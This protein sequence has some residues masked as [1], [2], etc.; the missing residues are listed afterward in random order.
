[1]ICITSS[2][3]FPDDERIY[4][5]QIKS[6]VKNKKK[7]LYITRSQKNID[8]SNDL[9]NHINL[10]ITLSSFLESALSIII[11][12]NISHL[13]VH[14]TNLLPLIKSIKRL[15]PSVV[16]I[17]DV[18]EDM[19]S[20]YRTFTTRNIFISEVAIYF[21]NKKEEYY[22]KYVDKIILANS[23]IKKSSYK[24]FKKELYFLENFPQKKYIR[25]SIKNKVRGPLIVYHGHLAP[26]RG[27]SDLVEAMVEVLKAEPL[28]TLTLLGTFRIESFKK[29]VTALIKK[30]KLEDCISVRAQIPYE[31]VWGVLRKH[32]IGVIPFRSNPLTENNT[33]TK[34]FEMMASGLEIVATDLHPIRYFL[35]KTIFWATPNQSSS[36]AESLIQAIKNLEDDSNLNENLE[37]VNQRY[38]WEKIELKYLSTFQQ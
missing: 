24:N 25:S 5:R 36:L 27:I 19:K 3:H 26:E 34:L 31:E 11:K 29:E 6:L 4:H 17:Y 32:A 16:T 2:S 35:N 10:D 1:M 30:Y 18:H 21:R 13:Q 7:I 33:P 12:N 15:E 22:L 38:N 23:T 8:L 20:L 37:L 9:L 14:E 28:A